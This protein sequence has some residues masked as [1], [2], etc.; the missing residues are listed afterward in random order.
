MYGCTACDLLLCF[1]EEEILLKKL[2][3]VFFCFFF[4]GGGGGWRGGM[5]RGMGEY[6]IHR[7][8]STE[9][10]TDRVSSPKKYTH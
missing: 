1:V 4:F 7:F 2:I 8:I 5:G 9:K 10:Q 6:F 3:I